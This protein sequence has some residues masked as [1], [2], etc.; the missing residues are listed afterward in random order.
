MIDVTS[1]GTRLKVDGKDFLI[2]GM[3]WDYFPI[4]KSYPFILWEQSDAFIKK[5]LDTE[6][7]LLKD[8]GVNTIR[9]Y[10]GIQPRWIQYIYEHYGIYTILNATFG[11]YGVSVEGQWIPNTDYSDP[12]V[13]TTLLN[14][15]TKLAM[16]C[17]DTPGL[18]LYLVGNENN[19][20][21]FWEGAETENIPVADRKST[22]RARHMYNLI[23]K[24]ALAIKAIDLSHPV[25]MCN[26][27]LQFLDLI[28]KECPDVDIFGS[29]IY[30]GESFDNTFDRVKAEYGKPVLLTEF[31]ADAFNMKTMTEDQESQA[32]YLKKNWKEIYENVAGIGKAG[33][34]I[35]GCTFQFSDGWW[36]YD[37][38]YRL[39]IHDTIASWS[40]GGYKNDY[41][42]TVNNMNEEWFGICSKGATDAQGHYTLTPRAAYYMLKS[43][44]SFN[45]LKPGT[46]INSIQLHFDKK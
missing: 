4:G 37:Q 43:V 12:R 33:N 41:T 9:V 15:V 14:E 5:A 2:K 31:G 13:A 44:H 18:L 36:K 10:A 1:S 21:L 22:E 3:N 46:N 42:L 32:Y 30:R 39:D 16:E 40:N 26:G 23:N 24:G 27:D 8:M 38:T 35:G 20:G 17:K 11:R 19:Y 7:T 28:A 29:N 25:A 45:P 34:S 6:M